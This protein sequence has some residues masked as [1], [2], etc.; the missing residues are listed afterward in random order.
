MTTNP[1]K[2]S[3]SKTAAKVVDKQHLELVTEVRALTYQVRDLH[4]IFVR[5]TVLWWVLGVETILVVVAIVAIFMLSIGNH[6]NTQTVV[7]RLVDSCQVRNQQVLGT[8]HFITR[9]EA[10]QTEA[11][12]H[13]PPQFQTKEQ[14]HLEH[15]YTKALKEWKRSQPKPF[16]C[17][18]YRP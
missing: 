13:I 14:R 10:L 11:Y 17:T 3:Q 1:R 16:N 4:N 8:N 18:N 9:I 2:L 15:E 7:N 5:R 12:K 6:R